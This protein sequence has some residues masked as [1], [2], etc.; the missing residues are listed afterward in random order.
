M[1][2]VLQTS[3]IFTFSPSSRAHRPRPP[4]RGWRHR[5]LRHHRVVRV[6]HNRWRSDHRLHHREVRLS[7]A[8]MDAGRSRE[9]ARDSVHADQPVQ[10]Y[11]VLHP[12]RSRERR[13]LLRLEGVRRTNETYETQKWV[14]KSYD[15]YRYLLMIIHNLHICL[16]TLYQ[17]FD[18]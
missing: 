17:T 18:N 5:R 16:L 11:V 7:V 8:R 13:R 9:V 12:G 10:Y 3:N 2:S 15:E 4:A 1:Y 6:Y 14:F